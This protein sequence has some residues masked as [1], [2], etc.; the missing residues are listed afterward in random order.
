[1][2]KFV[3]KNALLLGLSATLCV[4]LIAGVNVLTKER[5]AAQTLAQKVALLQEVLPPGTAD[6]SV[7]EN[8]LY[9]E[10]KSVFGAA[11]TPIYR[12]L[13]EGKTVYVVET[14][15][16]DGYSGNIEL[17]A[18]IRDDAT[19]LAVRTLKHQETPGLGDKIDMQ[20]GDWMLSFN[21]VQVQGADDKRIAVRKDGGQF[22]QFTGATITPR[23]VVGA[24]KR[25]AI[26]LQQHPE[27][28][29][30][31]AACQ[32]AAAEQAQ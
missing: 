15:A 18:A 23:A 6:L 2:L 19:I 28:A 7:L 13:V 29:T 22:D 10:D 11:R 27:L 21:G 17:L 16:P 9:V 4:G 12:T 14:T 26:Y 31:P 20:K 25:A 8:C 24:V 32:Q 30:A 3:S 1:M 5:I